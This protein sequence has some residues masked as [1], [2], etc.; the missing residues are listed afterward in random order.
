MSKR[1]TLQNIAHHRQK[2]LDFDIDIY[3]SI[4]HVFY[5]CTKFE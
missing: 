5:L 1:T 2:R 4:L 3:F